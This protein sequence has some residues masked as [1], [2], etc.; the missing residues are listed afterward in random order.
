VLFSPV[1]KRKAAQAH[2]K[3]ILQKVRVVLLKKDKV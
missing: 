3:T 1:Q 2:G